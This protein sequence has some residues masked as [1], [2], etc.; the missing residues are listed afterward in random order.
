MV[1]AFTIRVSPLVSL[2]PTTL[3][4]V[5]RVPTLPDARRLVVSMDGG[6][7]ATSSTLPVGASSTY[8]VVWR[9]VPAGAYTVRAEIQGTTRTLQTVQTQV[10]VGGGL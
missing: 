6:S 3:T 1:L 5:L 2:A 9:G 10:E 7:Y 8:R 4:V